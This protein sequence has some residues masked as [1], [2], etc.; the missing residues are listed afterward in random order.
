MQQNSLVKFRWVRPSNVNIRPRYS[1]FTL[2]AVEM[3]DK[4]MIQYINDR[5][6]WLFEGLFHVDNFAVI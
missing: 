1:V 6:E 3:I 2:R 5:T 4:S